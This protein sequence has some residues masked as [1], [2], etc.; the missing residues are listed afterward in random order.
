MKIKSLNK[1]LQI[2]LPVHNEGDFILKLLAKVKKTLNKKINFQF[3]ISEDGS[4][5]S[6]QKKLKKNITKYKY[7]L[8]TQKKRLGYSQAVTNGIRKASSKYLLIMDSDGQC[9]WNDIIRLWKKRN[10]ADIIAGYRMNR[11]DY[12][13]R[14][15]FSNLCYFVY[16]ILFNVPLKD[17]SFGFSLINKKVYR[18]MIFKKNMCPV[19][20]FWEFNAIASMKNF[21]FKEVNINH[22]KRASGKTKIYHIYDLPK[23]AFQH[24]IG[25][26]IV[27]FTKY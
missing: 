9:D 16:K 20:F 2:L 10:E 3:I 22:K 11:K 13:Y 19:G 14:K 4:T 26:L 25:L 21:T 15:F 6:T 12:M 18:S 23:I 8:L 27:K 1:E 17:P 5:D 7:I 24:L